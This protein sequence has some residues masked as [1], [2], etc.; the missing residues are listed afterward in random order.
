MTWEKKIPENRY[1]RCRVQKLRSDVAG[2]DIKNKKR[3]EITR[4]RTTWAVMGYAN[5]ADMFGC[6]P[7]LDKANYLKTYYRLFDNPKC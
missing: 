1:K 5:I 4:F 2:L 7:H 3:V 6:D